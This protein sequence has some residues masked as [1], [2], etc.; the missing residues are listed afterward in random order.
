MTLGSICGPK[1]IRSKPKPGS[2]PPVIARRSA[3]QP[4]RY[5]ADSAL[6]SPPLAQSE[7]SATSAIARPNAS[8][9]EVGSPEMKPRPAWRKAVA[10]FS[11]A[12]VGQNMGLI[13]IK[14]KDWDQRKRSGLDMRSVAQR[15]SARAVGRLAVLGFQ[16][17]WLIPPSKRTLG[18]HSGSKD[19]PNEIVNI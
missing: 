16:Y 6:R 3:A 8:S 1:V 13:F 11:F 12:G 9:T 18:G 15:A 17:S 19:R 2:G 7:N 10:G 5:E 14:L 4:E